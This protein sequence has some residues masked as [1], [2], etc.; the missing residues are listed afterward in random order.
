MATTFS[1]EGLKPGHWL[2][3]WHCNATFRFRDLRYT[4]N[5]RSNQTCPNC[6]AAGIGFDIHRTNKPRD[7][8]MIWHPPENASAPR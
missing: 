2:V 5:L 6:D 8:S 4:P 1:T 3:C 7:D